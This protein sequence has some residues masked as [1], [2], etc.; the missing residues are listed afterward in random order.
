[1]TVRKTSI[2]L[3]SQW[4]RFLRPHRAGEQQ[5]DSEHTRI[6]ITLNHPHQMQKEAAKVDI[7]CTGTKLLK[8][9]R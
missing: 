2:A 9:G 4:D 1:M 7:T 5:V 8:L 3:E 6:C